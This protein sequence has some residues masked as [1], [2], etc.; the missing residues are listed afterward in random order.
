MIGMRMIK[1]EQFRANLARSSLG[2]PI[3][4]RAHEKTASRT[5][6]GRVR[7]PNGASHSSGLANQCPTTLVRIGLFPVTPNGCRDAAAKR[8]MTVSHRR[9]KTTPKDTSPHR[10]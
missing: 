3:I 2:E 10:R 7:Q 6:F 4:G 1:P 8:N 9:S 5:F